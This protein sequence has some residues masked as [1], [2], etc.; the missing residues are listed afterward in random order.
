MER[1]GERKRER[2]CWWEWEEVEASVTYLCALVAIASWVAIV[3]RLSLKHTHSHKTIMQTWSQKRKK[4]KADSQ[5][6]KE[7]R[8]KAT[9]SKKQEK[10]E[11]PVWLHI[12]SLIFWSYPNSTVARWSSGTLVATEALYRGIISGLLHRPGKVYSKFSLFWLGRFGKLIFNNL[13]QNVVWPAWTRWQDVSTANINSI[14]K[15]IRQF[16]QL[17]GIQRMQ[18]DCGPATRC[19]RLDIPWRLEDL[20]ARPCRRHRGFH[21]DLGCPRFRHVPR[22]PAR[23]KTTKKKIMTPLLLLT[24]KQGFV[25]PLEN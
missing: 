14:T 24:N 13:E 10:Q 18:S 7:I 16:L 8:N 3:S 5:K 6:I 25:S 15:G 23:R 19:D 11:N 12:K 21:R 22:V 1:K 20:V 17:W 2:V 4:E 9:K